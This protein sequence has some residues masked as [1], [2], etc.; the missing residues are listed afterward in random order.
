MSSAGR[1][2]L[3]A[4]MDVARREA[5]TSLLLREAEAVEELPLIWALRIWAKLRELRTFCGVEDRLMFILR[6]SF[7]ALPKPTLC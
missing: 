1:T 2:G 6:V 4:T 7:Y 3:E 5:R